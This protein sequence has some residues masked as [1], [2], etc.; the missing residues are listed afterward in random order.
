MDTPVKRRLPTWRE[1]NRDTAPEIE[2]KII[3]H[4]R[5]TPLWRKLQQFNSLNRLVF[6]MARQQVQ[7]R[8]PDA[9]PE[10]LRYYLARY[11]HGP[12]VAAGLK[13]LGLIEDES[14]HE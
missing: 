3:A 7:E 9:S 8:Y 5:K 14:V 4:W 12:I 6:R 13:P 1:M 10:A 2:A 11:L